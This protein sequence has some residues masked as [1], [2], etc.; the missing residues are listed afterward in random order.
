[1]RA[2][3]DNIFSFGMGSYLIAAAQTGTEIPNV[4]V[5]G[6]TILVLLSA[7]IA[8]RGYGAHAT[9]WNFALQR[10]DIYGPN[11]ERHDTALEMYDFTKE[12]VAPYD[13]PIKFFVSFAG[14]LVVMAGLMMQG[15]YLP[16]AAEAAASALGYGFIHYFQ[17]NKFD[18]LGQITGADEDTQNG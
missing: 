5:W 6:I 17:V 2:A 4:L 11:K 13:G 15:W 12:A 9:F 1:M 8:L 18:I 14:S 10:L 7:Y 3:V 16:L